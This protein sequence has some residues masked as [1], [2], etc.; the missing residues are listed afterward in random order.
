MPCAAA[1]AV[2]EQRQPQQDLVRVVVEGQA[3][4]IL[5][6]SHAGWWQLV[7]RLSL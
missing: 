3:S 5:G 2:G 6:G 7:L 1:S 4:S